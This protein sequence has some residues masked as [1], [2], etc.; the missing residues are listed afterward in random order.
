[1]AAT[2]RLLNQYVDV[3]WQTEQTARLVFDPEWRG[4][5]HVSSP[6]SPVSRSHAVR[7][8]DEDFLEQQRL[9]QEARERKEREERERAAREEAER[10]E[11][12]RLEQERVQAEKEKQASRAPAVRGVR[13]LRARAGAPAGSTTSRAGAQLRAEPAIELD[14]NRSPSTAR[15]S[16]A[17]C[18][19]SGRERGV[20][21]N[22][23]HCV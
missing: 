7:A 17:A 12:E 20:S 2:D 1:M 15:K 4:G 10:L 23:H 14:C 11:R 5:E 16:G 22:L 8:Q 6:R 18:T 3:V 9:A 19:G 13:G 21:N